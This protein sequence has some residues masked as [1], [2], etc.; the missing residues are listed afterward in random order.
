MDSI[1]NLGWPST[2]N[3]S[4]SY[5]PRYGPSCPVPHFFSLL[6]VK[7]LSTREW[8]SKSKYGFALLSL[9]HIYSNLPELAAKSI[10]HTS[11]SIITSVNSLLL[12]SADSPAVRSGTHLHFLFILEPPLAHDDVFNSPPVPKLLLKD[13]IVLEEF[14]GLLF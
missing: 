8:H 7:G 3:F 14:L 13:G 6:S 4:D 5:L 2:N 12:E 1:G 11:K 9:S 10:R